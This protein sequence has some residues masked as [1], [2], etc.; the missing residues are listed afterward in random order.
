MDYS[1]D[2]QTN[3]TEA[4]HQESS[5]RIVWQGYLLKA[6]LAFVIIGVVFFAG[7]LSGLMIRRVD[8]LTWRE[9]Y[10]TMMRPYGG[11][12]YRYQDGWGR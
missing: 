1:Q 11:M 9:G 7:L 10:P 5:H 12:M 6:I 4:N 3:K 2:P 8:D